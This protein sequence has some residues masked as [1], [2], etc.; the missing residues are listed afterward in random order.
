MSHTTTHHQLVVLNICKPVGKPAKYLPDYL[1][2][3]LSLCLLSL[4]TWTKALRFGTHPPR[5]RELA[6]IPFWLLVES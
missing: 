3:P 2:D 5:Q 1:P 4:L 6:L